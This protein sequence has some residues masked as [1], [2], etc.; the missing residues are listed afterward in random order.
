MSEKKGMPV[1]GWVLIGCGGIT[2][3]GL[4]VFIG[5]GVFV[6]KKGSE[7][8]E[9]AERNPAHA[10]AKFV[11]LADKN[12]EIVD[13]NDDDQTV[14]LKNVSTGEVVTI[15]KSGLEDG[16][17]TWFNNGNKTTFDINTDNGFSISTDSADGEQELSLGSNDPPP[18]WVPSYPGSE[19]RNLSRITSSTQGESGTIA[20]STD[21]DAVE[22][23]S[24]FKK[25]LEDE[26][27]EVKTAEVNGA[28]TV[29]GTKDGTTVT[30]TIGQDSEKA[31]S[32]GMIQ[33][34]KDP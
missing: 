8:V 15:D 19:M 5:M 14:T 32:A 1:W 25:T 3:L 26:G 33:Y 7:F 16:Q 21:D 6:Y 27:Y 13:H 9:A 22:V 31:Q 24:Y 23:Q 2:A 29:V 34:K 30:T 20:F 4:V 10:L 18:E 12:I 17:I 28:F 11:A